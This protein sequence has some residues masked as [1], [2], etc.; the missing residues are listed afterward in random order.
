ML[1]AVSDLIGVIEDIAPLCLAESW[2]NVG[3]QV[4][5]M[6]QPVNKVLIALDPSPEV[7][8]DACAQGVDMLVTHHPLIFHP[9]TSVSLD[10][11]PGNV[12]ADAVRHRLAIYAAHTNLDSCA[13]GINDLLAERL[14][15]FNVKVLKAA[16]SD[17]YSDAG[18]GRTGNLERP[19]KLKK[20]VGNIME[21][22]HLESVRVAG[23]PDAVIKDVCICCGSGSGLLKEFLACGAQVYV[24]G[25]LHYHDGRIA[26]MERKS[27]V[28]IGHFHSEH[29]IV[30]ALAAILKEH[31]KNNGWDLVVIPYAKERDPFGTLF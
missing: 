22:L 30:E 17:S 6:D 15:L 16:K 25:D 9:V 31:S 12:I 2:D 18:L 21:A 8:S 14:N 11:Y 3:L 7:V 24:S 5:G 20:F 4:G 13:G 1:P 26:E 23:N 28:D 10:V 27:L 29:L 19:I